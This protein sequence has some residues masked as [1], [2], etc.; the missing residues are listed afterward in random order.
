MEQEKRP[1]LDILHH[2]RMTMA[3]TK[4]AVLVMRR[5]ER[6]R[7]YVAT[8]SPGD[9]KT[10]YRFFANIA[11]YSDSGSLYTALGIAEAEIWLEGFVS[12]KTQRG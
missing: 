3:L 5:A 12:G 4:N 8:Y 6:H 9:G 1:A 2:G 7:L 11:N 10:R